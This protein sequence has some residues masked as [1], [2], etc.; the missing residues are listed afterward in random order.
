MLGE[1]RP[2][3]RDRHALLLTDVLENSSKTLASPDAHGFQPIA[4]TTP[5]QFAK[6]GRE[7]P[8]TRG[9]DRMAE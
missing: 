5:P 8:A 4:G 6:E 1:M 9:T 7:N 2:Q 3:R